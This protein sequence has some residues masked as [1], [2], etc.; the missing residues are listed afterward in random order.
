MLELC[1]N[2]PV[3]FTSCWHLQALFGRLCAMR[4][5]VSNRT[6]LRKLDDYGEKFDEEVVHVKD[7]VSD[8]L[9]EKAQIEKRE[10]SLFMAIQSAVTTG[11][12][13]PVSS[14]QRNLA[15]SLQSPLCAIQ[16][17]SAT[18]SSLPVS[19]LQS[20]LAFSQQSPLCA[21]Q[22]QSEVTTGSSLPV[23]SLQTNV[24]DSQQSSLH[25]VSRDF[26]CETAVSLP[27]FA[28]ESQKVSVSKDFEANQ[29]LKASLNNGFQFVI[30][31]LDLRQDVK[32]MR[33]DNQN[34]DFHWTNMNFVM[35]RVSG[36]H[37]PDDEPIRQ[38]SDLPNGAVLP[39]AKDHPN[40]RENY[41]V[42]VG[43][44]ITECIPALNFLKHAVQK[45]IH[46]KYSVE[47]AQCSTKVVKSNGFL[48]TSAKF[49]TWTNT[50]IRSL[51]D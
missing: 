10:N 32:D 24:A 45:H 4:L 33:S 31:N 16:D 36:L 48:Q 7:K 38:L 25:V 42:L 9:K 14:L 46:H 34:K 11:S 12:S 1:S 28:R 19:S 47:M 20:N 40:S 13:L 8:Q 15:S 18:G 23:S 2:I 21:I 41:I 39:Q 50:F 49:F 43:R 37:L 30:D 35:N 6:L 17:H 3:I 22:H 5:S 44:I 29:A 26:P 27:T 51:L